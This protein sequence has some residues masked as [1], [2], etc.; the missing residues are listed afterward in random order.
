MIT[1][2][3]QKQV[4]YFKVEEIWL[5]LRKMGQS[6]LKESFLKEIGKEM[7]SFPCSFG[8]GNEYD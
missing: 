8:R 2:K 1:L 6:L 3:T 5:F 7:V 4:K